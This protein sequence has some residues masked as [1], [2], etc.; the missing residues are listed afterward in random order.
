MKDVQRHLGSR[1]STSPT[2][3]PRRVFYGPHRGHVPR[4]HPGDGPSGRRY[5]RVR[6]IPTPAPSIQ[7]VPEPATAGRRIK[8]LPISGE[9][10]RPPIS[11]RAA[12]SIRGAPN[13][14]PECREG[15]EPELQ[16]IGGGHYH[17]CK[18]WKE[19]S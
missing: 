3:F 16:D 15:P 5:R 19:I 4:A 13:A 2:I 8:E 7:A 9:I 6:R 14:A 11:P 17:A 12:A 10:P 18:R 1:T